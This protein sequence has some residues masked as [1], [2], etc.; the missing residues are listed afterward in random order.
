MKLHD[1]NSY[2]VLTDLMKI[3][4]RT[5]EQYYKGNELNFSSFVLL[6]KFSCLTSKEDNFPSFVR[7]NWGRK[8]FETKNPNQPETTI[9]KPSKT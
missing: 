7:R 8:Q 2:G 4:K 5:C 3:R 1:E 6:S 9:S